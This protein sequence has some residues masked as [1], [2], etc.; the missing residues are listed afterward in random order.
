MTL[1]D[2]VRALL[3]EYR[4]N[5]NRARKQHDVLYSVGAFKAADSHRVIAGWHGRFARD[6]E[7]VLESDD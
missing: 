1:E 3:A 4:D 5:E 7:R 6:L 2:R